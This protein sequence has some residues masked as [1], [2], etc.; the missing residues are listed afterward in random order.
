MWLRL[1]RWS[2]KW[3]SLTNESYFFMYKESMRLKFQDWNNWW[4]NVILITQDKKK[5]KTLFPILTFFLNC[6]NVF[7]SGTTGGKI[8]VSRENNSYF[9]I[10]DF[11]SRFQDRSVILPRLKRILEN[12]VMKFCILNRINATLYGSYI[13]IKYTVWNIMKN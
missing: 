5:I 10:E 8:F 9:D 7:S 12:D 3:W 6:L 1:F 2:L 4:Q 11:K 13:K